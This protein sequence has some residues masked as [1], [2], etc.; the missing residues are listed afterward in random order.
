M[1][2]YGKSK[3]T[4][5]NHEAKQIAQ[6][7]V[8]RFFCAAPDRRKLAFRRGGAVQKNGICVSRMP[9]CFSFDDGPRRKGKSLAEA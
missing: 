6:P 5:P 9:L 3:N 4:Q 2:I 8:V 7:L 1:E